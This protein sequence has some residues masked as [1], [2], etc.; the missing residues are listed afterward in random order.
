MVA[1]RLAY[2]AETYS[3]L[4]KNQFGARKR[5]STTQALAILQEKIYEAWQEGKVLSLISL[6]VKGAYN[7]VDKAV[8]LKRSRQ[9]QIPG[10]L[11]RWV[12]AFCSDRQASIVVN[13]E[14]S[15]T[16]DLPHAGLSQGSPLSPI[17]FLFFSADL[18]QTQINKSRGAI[19]FVH[20][21]NAW[22][23]GPT[24]EVNVRRIQEDVV[25]KAEAWEEASGASFAPEKTVLV[26]FSR[27]PRRL[28]NQVPL[29]VRGKAIMDSP[30][31]K[32]L[33]VILNQGLKYTIHA[34]RM[35]KRALTAVRM[36]KSL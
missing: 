4:P 7:E 21:Y 12:D 11:V 28:I 35:T 25:S 1:N 5:R 2:L 33:G 30:Q 3:L 29:S 27:N 20:D 34:A 26:H 16:V 19:A 13:G 6:D 17:L 9:R 14:V 23:T 22:V 18:V 8:L 15:A 32:L 31:A 24:S 10:T 36:L